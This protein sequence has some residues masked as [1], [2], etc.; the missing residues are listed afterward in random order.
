MRILT[1]LISTLVT[2]FLATNVCAGN[3]KIYKKIPDGAK[4]A[5]VKIIK[6]PLGKKFIATSALLTASSLVYHVITKPSPP[7]AAVPESMPN[8]TNPEP[9]S[10]SG[11]EQYRE[12]YFD[13]KFNKLIKVY[14]EQNGIMYCPYAIPSQDMLKEFIENYPPKAGTRKLLIPLLVRGFGGAFATRKD[15]DHYVGLVIIFDEQGEVLEIQYIDPKGE[16][17]HEELQNYLIKQFKIK[18]ITQVFNKRHHPQASKDN[19]NCGPSLVEAFK[20][21]AV[22]AQ[23]SAKQQDWRAV[24]MQHNKDLLESQVAPDDIDQDEASLV[25]ET[26]KLPPLTGSLSEDDVGAENLKS[27][28]KQVSNNQAAVQLSQEQQI[29]QD[30]YDNADVDTLLNRYTEII[31]QETK[32]KV[33]SYAGL[34]IDL[35]QNE[36]F[37]ALLP[38][39]QEYTQLG[40]TGGF[41]FILIPILTKQSNGGHFTG[42]VLAVK[43]EQVKVVYYIDS[44]GK[45]IPEDILAR[46]K[47]Q[48]PYAV[49]KRVFAEDRRPQAVADMTNGGVYLVE[50]M[51]QIAN[52]KKNPT[53]KQN[54][55]ELRQEHKKIIGVVNAGNQ[56]APRPESQ[57]APIQPDTVQHETIK[58]KKNTENKKTK[59]LSAPPKA[60]LVGPS[61]TE[62]ELA[63]FEKFRNPN[64]RSKWGRDLHQAH[65]DLLNKLIELQKEQQLDGNGQQALNLIQYFK[66]MQIR[67]YERASK[68]NTIHPSKIAT[69]KPAL[70]EAELVDFKKFKDTKNYYNW[71]NNLHKKYPDLLVRLTQ[72]QEEQLIDNDGL[73]AFK[74]IDFYLKQKKIT[75]EV[76]QEK[77]RLYALGHSISDKI[78]SGS[79]KDKLNPEEQKALDTYNYKQT[80]N[81]KHNPIKKA[82]YNLG[83]EVSVKIETG[84]LA[85]D[86]LTKEQQEALQVYEYHKAITKKHKKQYEHG[87]EIFFAIEI[88][89]TY[90]RLSLNQSQSEALAVFEVEREQLRVNRERYNH[91]KELAADIEKNPLK[92]SSLD[93]EQQNAL[94]LFKHYREKQQKYDIKYAHGCKLR[95]A[96][97]AG[98]R[99]EAELNNE[100]LADL[101]VYNQRKQQNKQD[102]RKRVMS[103]VV[104]FNLKITQQDTTALEGDIDI[105]NKLIDEYHINPIVVEAKRAQAK[106]TNKQVKTAMYEAA[107]NVIAKQNDECSMFEEESDDDI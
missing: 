78:K 15:P 38:Q 27:A 30:Q 3:K 52:G 82:N 71:G 25:I 39:L 103:A 11:E 36:T 57:P 75:D 102:Y 41:D 77:I 73:Q 31:R 46:L 47:Q 79:S 62:A 51:R 91:G 48:Y 16:K 84:K 80:I 12:W 19:N 28:N 32:I 6:S 29:L 58:L 43:G 8:S 7:A 104:K 67:D 90:T 2:L 68:H 34:T 37:D 56:P 49:I 44:T 53:A 72:L 42:L 92:E 33:E 83:R 87:R 1:T 13:D 10:S 85:K 94:G 96:I 101:R 95:C 63:D 86:K 23:Y 55:I 20:A 22:G 9:S 93:K 60:G 17:I 61:L 35:D 66:R 69:I 99:M 14:C 64:N 54:A 89:G 106:L 4:V 59:N 70:T 5:A 76:N 74:V 105:L 24:R 50:T 81:Q 107:E 100:E 40:F 88:V 18:K 65:P 21:A 45:S 98:E 26:N 97:E